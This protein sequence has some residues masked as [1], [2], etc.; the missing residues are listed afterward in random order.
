MIAWTYKMKTANI[1]GVK[2]RFES[3][4]KEGQEFLPNGAWRKGH[5]NDWQSIPEPNQSEKIEM[6]TGACKRSLMDKF[7]GV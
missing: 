2:V 1:G 7:D 5:V 4:P 3:S 6:L